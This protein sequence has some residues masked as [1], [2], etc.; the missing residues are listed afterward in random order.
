MSILSIAHRTVLLFAAFA[1]KNIR[2]RM[3][4]RTIFASGRR[5]KLNSFEFSEK[6]AAVL[7]KQLW[8]EFLYCLRS[9]DRRALRVLA[10]QLVFA[11]LCHLNVLL[12]YLLKAPF[13]VLMS[14]LQLVAAIDRELLVTYVTHKLLPNFDVQS[15]L[16][17]NL[18][19]SMFLCI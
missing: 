7:L 3:E 18:F 8:T 1:H 6:K 2:L 16:F 4:Q 13:V 19:L 10:L 17:Q 15:L 11:H 9:Y 5:T 14:A 12:Y